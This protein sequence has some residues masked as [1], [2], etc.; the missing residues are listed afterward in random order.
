M[1]KDKKIQVPF[2]RNGNQLDYPSYG[3]STKDN[4]KFYDTLIIQDPT[5]GYGRSSNKFTLVSK[6]DGKTYKMFPIDL[7]R[8]MRI[9]TSTMG[10]Q[11]SGKWTF[12]RRGNATGIIYIEKL[13]SAI[14]IKGKY[15]VR[16][17]KV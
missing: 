15:K 5:T 14:I 3:D 17:I 4:Y 11:I 10:G 9:A 16:K 6:K 2:D 1:A 13:K 12:T 7:V 8:L